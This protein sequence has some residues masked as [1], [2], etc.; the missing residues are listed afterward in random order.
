LKVAGAAGSRDAWRIVAELREVGMI[1][2]RPEL[3]PTHGGAIVC[4]REQAGSPVK[5]LLVKATGGGSWVLPKGH[6]ERGEDPLS[7]AK[8]ELR[9]EASIE[10]PARAEPRGV[11]FD[12]FKKGDGEVRCLYYV[13][14][15]T[16]LDQARVEDRLEDREEI[17][18]TQDEYE[19]ALR[20]HASTAK[21]MEP[22]DLKGDTEQVRG[23]L[24]N[25]RILLPGLLWVLQEAERQFLSN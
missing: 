3:R 24:A 14:H 5:F 4:R 23:E 17:W 12:K 13:L 1:A 21:E 10:W 11:I 18:I 20:T 19:R 9:E 22:G 2:G 15:L 16:D 25:S 7:C 6:I 8:R